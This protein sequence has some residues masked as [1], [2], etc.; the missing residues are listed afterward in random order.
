MTA[1]RGGDRAN[2]DRKGY[3]LRMSWLTFIALAVGAAAVLLL[4][5]LGRTRTDAG[6][7]EAERAALKAQLA[8]AGRDRAA[9]LIEPEQHEELRA[10]IARRL[11]RLEDEGAPVTPGGARSRPVLIA[12]ALVVPVA[13]AALY[14][15]VGR[16][17]L[18]SLPFEGRTDAPALVARAEAH[19]ARNPDDA[20]GWAAIAPFY[21]ALNRPADAV[22]AYDAALRGDHPPERE[23]A[24]LTDRAEAATLAQ[25]KAPSLERANLERAVAL[26]PTA[27]KPRFLLALATE[28]GG[29]AGAAERAWDDLLRRYPDA[30]DGWV[31]VARARLANARA[32]ANGPTLAALPAAAR[33]DAIE[34]MV[35]S[36]AARL[37]AEPD[38]VEGWARLIR[39]YAVLGRAGA[40]RSALERAEAQFGERPVELARVRSEAEAAGVALR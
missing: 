30:K 33:S 10:E 13:A 23:A 34:G 14:L 2:R 12:T 38:D 24:L 5:L 29:N 25:N 31:S 35:A 16:P 22:L 19:L 17:G 9:G 18:P 7:R 11:F 40:A 4:P 39:S 6:G 32:A 3:I 27:P 1:C 26:D 20:R 21:R 36:L 37:E 28:E 8:E 15:A